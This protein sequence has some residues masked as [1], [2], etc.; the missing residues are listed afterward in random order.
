L[1]VVTD[2]DDYSYRLEWPH[3]RWWEEY[4]RWWDDFLTDERFS[5]RPSKPSEDG[6]TEYATIAS[7]ISLRPG[8]TKQVV[9]IL[10]W[11]FPN[12]ENYWAR[13][14]EKQGLILKNHYGTKWESAW[15]PAAHAWRNLESLQRR[16]RQ[17]RDSL[18]SSTIPAAVI[19]AVS[20]QASTIRT[21]TVMV[22]EDKL[23]LA[24]EGCSDNEG[25]CPMNCTHV[26][27]YEQAMAHLYPDLERNMRDTDFLMNLHGDG[28]MSFRTVLPLEP[29]GNYWKAAA[30][31]QMGSILKVYRE[32]RLCGDDAWLRKLWPH[33]KRALEYAWTSWDRDR[34]GVIEGEQHNTYDIEFYGPNSLVGTLY[35]GAL[36]AASKMAQHLGDPDS[37]RVYRDLFEQGG[38]RM[39]QLLWN[40]DYYVQ[41]IDEAQEKAAKYQYG[42]GCLSDQLLGQW[43]AEIVDLGK[44][45]PHE[46]IRTALRSIFRH[47]FR[48]DF[49]DLANV[50]RIYA[51]NDE[52][53]LLV[54]S[55][56]KG[57]RPKLAFFYSDEVWTG[58]EYQVAAHLIYEG[59][60]KEGLAI[61]EAVRNRYDGARRNPWNE[62]ECGGH[63]ARAMSSW[64][65]L[66]AMSGFTH[67][68]PEKEMRF[69][70]AVRRS[71]FRCLYCAG[72]AWGNYAQEMT[73]ARTEVE[74][75]V[76]GG[77][78]ELSRLKVPFTGARAEVTAP[79]PATVQ[80]SDGEAVVC[81]TPPLKLAGGERLAISVG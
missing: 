24:F 64:S 12:V 23:V 49:H 15:E 29:G 79:A 61:V 73:K 53:G 72:T 60:I 58:I 41:R 38:K 59:M 11:H 78:L 1:A 31:G 7:H 25:C 21:N 39:D 40:G 32:W 10:S 20:S 16:S 4:Q 46:H 55:W 48:Q 43:F 47:N 13:P 50:Q 9:W 74:L 45:V 76:A 62:V 2:A 56:P 51:L 37:A 70:P 17:Y 77:M 28:A 75:T 81:F 35:L 54:C 42:E 14:N 65:L 69:G 19:D 26:Y 18:Y 67:S 52:K 30:D 36:L 33:V 5:S 68:A 44:L 63:Y 57:N 66:S 27:N 8:E 80:A 22:M 34:D 3:G 71:R 6:A